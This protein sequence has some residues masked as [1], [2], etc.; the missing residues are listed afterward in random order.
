MRTNWKSSSKRLLCLALVLAMFLGLIPTALA[1]TASD[2]FERELTTNVRAFSQSVPVSE[3]SAVHVN[4]TPFAYQDNSALLGQKITAIEIPVMK[5]AAIDGDQTFT[6]NVVAADS[7]K[8]GSHAEIRRTM[9]LTLPVDQLAGCTA[10]AVNKWIRIDGLNLQLAANETLAFGAADDKVTWGFVNGQLGT[11]PDCAFYASLRTSIQDVG[12]AVKILFPVYTTVEDTEAELRTALAGKSIAFMGD[13][14]TTWQGYSNNASRYNSTLGNNCYYYRDGSCTDLT[15]N[16]TWWMQTVNQLNLTLTANNSSSGSRVLGTGI[17]SHTTADQGYESRPYHLDDN[18]VSNNPGGA[19]VAPDIIVVYMGVNDAGGTAG[20]FEAIDFSTLITE[21]NGAYQYATPGNF[22]EAYAVMIHKIKTTYPNAELFLCNLPETPAKWSRP[23]ENHNPVIAKIAKYFGAHLV[24][25]YSSKMSGAIE[26]LKYALDDEG[27]TTTLPAGSLHPNAAGFDVMTETLIAAMKKVYLAQQSDDGDGLVAHWTFDE[28]TSDGKVKDATGNGHDGTLYGTPEL[29]TGK[30]GNSIYLNGSNQYMMTDYAADLDFGSTD[31]FTLSAWAKNE[32][33]SGWR[34]VAG[35]GRASTT[36]WY[37]IYASSTYQ[38]SDYTDWPNPEFGAV[39][40]QWHQLTAA[41]DGSTKTVS[42]YYDGQLAASKTVNGPN[43]VGAGENHGFLVGC[44][45]ANVGEYFTGAVDNVRVYNRALRAAEAK[46]L[47]EADGAPTPVEPP[48]DKHVKWTGEWPNPAADTGVKNIIFDTDA[49]PDGD[50]TGALTMLLHY[51]NEGKVNLLAT[52]SD[53]SGPFGVP[54]LSAINTYYGYPDIPVGTLKT[55]DNVLPTCRGNQFNINL[56]ARYETSVKDGVTA[57]DAVDVYREVLSKAED[58]SVTIVVTGMQTNLMNLLKSEADKWSDLD[59]KALVAKK[60]KLVSIMGGQW[61]TGSEF[62]IENDTE[63]AKYVCDNW[64]TPIVYSGY[65]VGEGVHTGP[66][67]G[68]IE[69]DSPLRTAWWMMNSWDQTAV[70]YAVEGDCGFWTL[71]RGDADFNGSRNS[72]T[73]N[74]VDGAR[75]YLVEDS[76]LDSKVAEKISALANA[77]KKN[78]PDELEIHAVNGN[79]AVTT[80]TWT[81]RTGL[82]AYNGDLQTSAESGATMSLT[83]VGTSVDIYGATGVDNGKFDLYVDET[84]ITTVDTSAAKAPTWHSQWLYTVDGLE[85]AEH[86]VKLVLT[87]DKAVGIDFFKYVGA[88]LPPEPAKL[89]AH[90]TFD[91]FTE[92]GKVKD[93]TGNGH[94]GE[95]I[96]APTYSAGVSGN[97]VKFNGSNQAV[98]VPYA[99]ELDFDSSR[100][101][102]LSLWAKNEGGSGWRMTAGHGRHS[103]NMA[104]GIQGKWYGFYAGGDGNYQFSASGANYGQSKITSDWQLLTATYDAQTNMLTV[105]NNGMKVG[106][107]A[108]GGDVHAGSPYGFLMGWSGQNGSTNYKEYFNGMLDDVRAYSGVLSDA[109]IQALYDA[110]KNPPVDKTALKSAITSAEGKKEADYCAESWNAMQTALAAAK[111]VN[112]NRTAAQEHVDTATANLTAAL[113]KLQAHTW[114]TAWSSDADSHWHEC[115]KCHAKQ[116]EDTHDWGSGRV[117]TA[118]TCTTAGEKIYTCS[119]CGATKT[120]T[121][122]ATGHDY[123]EA[124]YKWSADGKSCTAERV[125]QNDKTHKETETAAAS[126]AVTTAPTCTSEGEGVYTASFKNKAFSQQTNPVKIAATGHTLTEHPAKAPTELAEGNIAYWKCSVCGRMFTDEAGLNEVFN[127]TLPKLTPTPTP[128]IP[129]TPSE[130]AQNPFNPNA[131]SDTTKFPF[132]DVPSDSWYY[133]SVKAAWENGLIDGVTANEFKPNATLTVAQTIKLAA[134]LHQ[135]DRTGEVS[136]KNGGANWYDSY[137]N[138]AVTNGIIEKDYANYTQAQMNAPV[139]RGEF[140]HI[141]HG[142]EEAFKAINTVADNAIPD[143]KTTDK[144]AAEIYEFYRAG[145][146][147]G[148]DAKGTFHSASTIKRS[149]AAAILLRMFEASARKSMTLK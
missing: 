23:V 109:E 69:A 47:Y 118:A 102:T 67:T 33:G 107:F 41:Y 120:E 68:K 51:M 18:T 55:K 60:V 16:D 104:A 116:D 139:T 132:L 101:Y 149:E 136:L 59:G 30:N 34:L 5:V 13:S 35:N 56:T 93:V 25:F 77:P 111:T 54:Y 1:G 28:L 115:S 45:G 94:D 96:N 108:G 20:S 27:K 65:T 121:I 148:S 124:T 85:K 130:P 15:V 42:L 114:R 72:F 134:A 87:E 123:G 31:S 75:A 81:Q 100:S 119:D 78:N 48:E 146:L 105:Y 66:D 4:D 2:S 50:D 8:T 7:L 37:G 99:A 95:P 57:R 138:Y 74:N 17:D 22:A 43:K 106:D 91:D 21:N 79:Q 14:I 24:D 32:G 110:V 61:P 52:V 113:D 9:K 129:V 76:A 62:N 125:C 82:N 53:T 135:L 58:S 71:K 117:T 70:L 19:T 127:V 3:M 36:A 10:D 103:R 38:F 63:A 143:V 131:G 73:E 145:I 49:G 140:V 112:E 98:T 144:F 88:K 141:F 90:W 44:S 26:Y 46:A 39:N 11:T 6:L 40:D 126:Y 133:S 89:L 137:V 80:G 92:D 86:T 29:K 83:F 147:T 122:H 64:P 128:V 97:G 142:A 12:A 84:K